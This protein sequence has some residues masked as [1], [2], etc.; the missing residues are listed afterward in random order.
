M[1]KQVAN[2]NAVI[3][4]Y[5]NKY[6]RTK[7]IFLIEGKEVDSLQEALLDEGLIWIEISVMFIS[8]F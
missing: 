2:I 4:I 3:A 7:K 1:V 5:E 8:I 6:D